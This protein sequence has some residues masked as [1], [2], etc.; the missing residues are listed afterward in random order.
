MDIRKI[1][2]PFIEADTCDAGFK[3]GLVLARHFGAHLDVVHARPRVEVPGGMYYPVVVPYVESNYDALSESIAAAARELK[4][5]FDDLCRVHKV[6]VVD[7]AR[8]RPEDMP[9]ASWTEFEARSVYGLGEYAR[10]GDL[11]VMVRPEAADRRDEYGLM[12]S[13][14]FGSAR[15]L[16][17]L[18]RETRMKRTP[19]TAILAW[20]GGLEAARALLAAR[21]LL[22]SARAV[23]VVSIGDLPPGGM[24]AEAAA[25]YLGLHGIDAEARHVE[26]SLFERAEDVMM[27]VIGADR[28]ELVVMGAYSHNR[29]QQA[30]LGGFTRRLLHEAD[31]PVLLAH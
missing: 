26:R 19:A 13:V 29:L 15:P 1:T 28:P 11:A 23:T 6:K 7:L 22:A 3:N 4:G 14:L 10:L 24:P 5:R 16:L 31:C 8:L 20:N 25:A 17:V 18:D 9:S 30:V 2:I 21:P 12:E 27:K